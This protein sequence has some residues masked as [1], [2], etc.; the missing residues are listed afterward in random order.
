MY[1]TRGTEG[2]STGTSRISRSI[3]QSSESSLAA[4]DGADSDTEAVELGVGG[5]GELLPV[6][7]AS[8][9]AACI[10]AI[11]S[12]SV[13]HAIEVPGLLTSGRA[14]QIVP[15][16]HGVTSH[17][18]PTHCAKSEPTHEGWVSIVTAV[19]QCSLTRIERYPPVQ[20]S[21]ALKVANCALSC[22]ASNAFVF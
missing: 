21:E 10:R 14:T 20:E 16:A 17:F 15:D 1:G 8:A 9:P 7:L 22:C 18:P 5:D 2:V 3:S 13:S 19:S 6:K 11:A 12:T 4:G